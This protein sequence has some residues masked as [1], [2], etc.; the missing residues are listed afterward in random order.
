MNNC[1]TNGTIKQ[2]ISDN[3]LEH[4]VKWKVKLI[5]NQAFPCG[6]PGCTYFLIDIL[7]FEKSLGRAL[8]F[9]WHILIHNIH[10]NYLLNY[11][12]EDSNR[13]EGRSC[14]RFIE[15]NVYFS[16]KS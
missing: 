12:V 1:K 14:P 7:S 5:S 16:T 15:T 3:C 9:H 10:A 4:N 11:A 2:L 6:I 13:A 8:D